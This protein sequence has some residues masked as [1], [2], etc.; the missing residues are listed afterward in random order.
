MKQMLVRAEE[1]LQSTMERARAANALRCVDLERRRQRLQDEAGPK[2]SPVFLSLDD[3]AD[4]KAQR[5]GQMM[6]DLTDDLEFVAECRMKWRLE[7]ETG[8]ADVLQDT[9]LRDGARPSLVP[10]LLRRFT[11]EP[12]ECRECD[13]WLSELTRGTGVDLGLRARG[14]RCAVAS[15]PACG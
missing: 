8:K 5:L 6:D 4:S 1:Q 10:C 15:G 13:R 3:M 14:G 2:A 11:R 9:R 12:K 7:E